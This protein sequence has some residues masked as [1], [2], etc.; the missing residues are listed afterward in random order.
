MA[1]AI[2]ESTKLE[3]AH[4]TCT[5]ILIVACTQDLVVFQ[6]RS[7][8][9][10]EGGSVTLNCSFDSKSTPKVGSYWWLK[11]QKVEVRNTTGEFKGRVK[12]TTDLDFILKKRA[13]IEIRELRHYDSGIYQCVVNIPGLLDTFGSG[14]ELRVIKTQPQP[15]PK[16]SSLDDS[17]VLFW[18]LLRGILCAFGMTTLVLVTRLYY[19]KTSKCS[20]G[21]SIF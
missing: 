19:E 13:N 8:E 17:L 10:T 21:P 5:I 11:D 16:A 4:S 3:L 7:A 12:L 20:L 15:V 18:L 1:V 2:Q 9:G 14:T 6:P